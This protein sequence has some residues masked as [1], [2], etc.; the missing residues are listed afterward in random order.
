MTTDK[1]IT[2]TLTLAQIYDAQ[3]Q[4]FDAFTIYNKLYQSNPSEDLKERMEATEKKIF[5]DM[6]FVYNETLNMIFTEEDRAKFKILPDE[7]HQ[8]LLE[9]LQNADTEETE[10]TEFAAEDF[11]E[12][13]NDMSDAEEIEEVYPDLPNYQEE[14]NNLTSIPSQYT[15]DETLIKDNKTADLTNLT[16]TELAQHIIKKIRTDKKLSDLTLKEIKEIKKIF[17]ELM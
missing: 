3:K 16:I 14:L 9:S 11:E 17:K 10:E 4:Y 6:S 8:N 5:T 1:K 15:F 7:N 13:E 12:N 2:P